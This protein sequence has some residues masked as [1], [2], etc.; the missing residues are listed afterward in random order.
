MFFLGVAGAGLALGMLLGGSLNGFASLRFRWPF[1]VLV[2]L[3]FKDLAFV[4]P[5]SK[6]PWIPY[7]Y[8]LSLIGLLAWTVYHWAKLPAVWLV[9]AGVAMNLMVVIANGGHMPVPLAL[10]VKAIPMARAAISSGS[11]GQYIIAGPQT[12]LLWL[13][14]WL[15]MPWPLYHFFPQAFSPGDF[16]VG[17]GLFGL[18]FLVCRPRAL[19]RVHQFAGRRPVRPEV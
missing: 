12:H 3:L 19:N 11:N 10:V 13:G 4:S 1:F 17:A 14:D 6:T 16:L 18:T 5:L 8:L 9:S 7:V 15:E 2:A